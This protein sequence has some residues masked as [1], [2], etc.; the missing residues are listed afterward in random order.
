MDVKINRTRKYRLVSNINLIDAAPP[1]TYELVFSREIVRMDL[2]L[3]A[4]NECDILCANAQKMYL[5]AKIKKNVY[6]ESS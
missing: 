4:L 2:I 6:F 5:N 3:E 1:M